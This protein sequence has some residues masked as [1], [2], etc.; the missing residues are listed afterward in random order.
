MRSIRRGAYARLSSPE[1]LWHAYLAVRSGKRR[2]PV[3]ADF[4]LNADRS[5]L[6]LAHELATGSYRPRPWQLRLVHDSKPRLIAAPAVRDRI[7]HRALLDEIG[8]HFERRFIHRHFTR[9]PGTGVHQAVLAFLADNRRWGWRMHLDIRHY[10][11]SVSHQRLEAL[12][13]PQIRDRR[14]RWLIR[15]VLESGER[16]Y[17][18]A[19]AR[20]TLAP[21]LLP[22][23]PRTGLPLGSWFSQWAGAYYLDGLDHYV[24]R[25]LKPGGYLRYMDDF[26]LFAEQAAV[27]EDARGAIRQWLAEHRGLTLNP[28]HWQIEPASTPAVFLGYRISSSGLGPSRRLRRRMRERIRNAAGRGP[29][30]LRQTLVSYRGMLRF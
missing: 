18:S 23:P 17:R 7:V 27:L 19:L 8:P 1:A 28:K 6:I 9:G 12:L 29:A 10:F 13:F 24:T 3:M 26:V 4:E 20:K 2:G 11:P 15:R 22:R 21:S 16:V 25:Q 30:A 5:V 14:V